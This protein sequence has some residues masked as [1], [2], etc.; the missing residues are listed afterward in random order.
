MPG[1]EAKLHI[2]AYMSLP[3][4]SRGPS[5]TCEKILTEMESADTST[6]LYTPADRR[7]KPRPDLEVFSVV[8]R[9]VRRIPF[10]VVSGV[11]TAIAEKKFRDACARDG[12]AVA[13]LW[14]E[15]S[16]PLLENLKQDGVLI[17]REKYNCSK[18]VARNILHR[19]YRDLGVEHEF[20][21]QLY[22]DAMIAEEAAVLDHSDFIIAPSP[23][24]K[25]SLLEV[26]VPEGKIVSA[27]YGF[28]PER[29]DTDARALKQI[30]GLTFIFV[31][32]V[33][34]RKGA[35]I[36]LEAWRRAN[37]RG[38][39]VLVGKIEPLIAK[40]YA[41]VLAQDN[42]EYHAFTDNVGSFFRSADYFVFPT[43]EEGSPL[44]T[45]EASYCQLPSI[46]S[47][48][49]AGEIIRDGVEGTVVTSDH[50]DAWAR[51]LRAAA[52]EYRT[53]SYRGKR[54][55]AHERSLE[56]TWDKV[57]ARRRTLL[58]EALGKSPSAQVS[59]P[60]ET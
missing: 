32:Y 53:D 51:A 25:A 37:V 54:V 18:L 38:R 55:A 57:G 56:F 33:C 36:L 59:D 1:R 23:M 3:L 44:V 26:G 6:T 58:R 10:A 43:L 35:H 5:Y 28:D 41:D 4:T 31:G 2:N 21:A 15:V 29:L 48:M 11:G 12:D 52:D 30:D 49:G 14:G 47:P 19:A 60:K 22:S 39:L 13:Y 16:V 50:I 34:V 42:V 8:S 45:Y 27:S 7:E 17:I 24:V 9:K 46:V 40:N 20:P